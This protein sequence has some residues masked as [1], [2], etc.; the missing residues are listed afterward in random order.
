M[1]KKLFQ[2]LCD[3]AAIGGNESLVRAIM[4]REL[5]KVS[6]EIITDKLG[7]IFGVKQGPKGAPVI[8][9]AGHMDEV[10][11][12]VIGIKDNGL[13]RMKAIGG[14]DGAVYQSQH[15]NVYTDAGK[16]IPG[17]TVT[18]PPHLLRDGDQKAP[19]T[20]FDDLLVDVGASSKKD[21]EKLGIQVGDMIVSSNEFKLTADKK[22][23]ISKAIDNRWGCY[24]AIEIL[25]EL[26]DL[27]VP[28]TV[29]AGANV[30]EEVGLRGAVVSTNMVKPDV[31]IALDAS[32][33]GDRYPGD[34]FGSLGKGFLL[35]V[36]DRVT[37]MHQGMKIVM[38]E[39]AQAEKLPYQEFYS[40]GGTDA[41]AAQYAGA[42]V[43]VA[44][45]G[46][47]ARY[48]HS[49]TSM[50]EMSDSDVALQM[51]KAFILKLNKKQLAKIQSLV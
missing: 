38:K 27:D 36:L 48:I 8:M 10:G 5:T 14:L 39:I 40:A 7:G 37:V 49:T 29:I 43:A 28:C 12:M 19:S 6:D 30:Q 50:M 15:M 45:I 17:V 35:R 34:Q 42:G 47:P 31:F 32:P 13:L 21:V 4:R 26:K 44:T 1:N 25:K 51:L 24:M 18:M 2:E 22:K 41:G 20:K 16:V 3:A 11:A 23:I 9:I 33:A 46:L